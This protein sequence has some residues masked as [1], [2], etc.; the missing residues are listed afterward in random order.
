LKDTEDRFLPC[1]HDL[2]APAV[3]GGQH[4]LIAAH[5]N[6]LRALVK[7]LDGLSDADIMELNIPTGIPLVYELD[8][9]LHPIR[10]YYLGDPERVQKAMQSV[11][12]Q[13]SQP[14]SEA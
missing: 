2:I 1:W 14:K 4:V 7:Y 9:D 12:N 8:E 13:A 10:H 11:A 3:R 6:T 5:G